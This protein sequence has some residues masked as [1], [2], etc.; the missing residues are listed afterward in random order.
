M[1]AFWAEVSS[2]H[3]QDLDRC[4]AFVDAAANAGCDAVKFQ[5]FRVRSLFAPEILSRSAVHRAREAWELPVSYLP[6]LATRCAERHVDFT[7]TPF[8]LKAVGELEPYVDA[9]KI[10]SYELLWAPLLEACAE[11]GKPVVLST[12]MATMDEVSGAV[13]TLREAGCA[14]LTLLHCVSAYPAPPEQCNLAAIDT[15]RRAFHCPVGWSDHSVSPAVIYRAAHRFGASLVEL[16]F[17][18]DGA[19]AE[20]GAGHCWLPETLSPVISE[21]RRGAL[22]DG[23]GHKGPVASEE[24]DRLWR[25]D[26]SDGLRPFKHVRKT[27]EPG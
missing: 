17:D 11:T 25:A 20:F 18:L 12:G 9:Y 14:D 10:A 15:L 27:F 16:H 2:N 23:D 24:P 6:H 21:V 22:A 3:G 7:C 26:P 13:D 19:G 1:T 8:D 4:L 5:L